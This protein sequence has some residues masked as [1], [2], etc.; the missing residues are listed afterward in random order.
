MKS[1]KK[2]PPILCI[3]GYAG[4]GNLG[5]DALLAGLLEGLW[6]RGIAPG[7]VILLSGRPRCDA[8]RFGVKCV[9]RKNPVAILLAL[10]RADVFLSGGG[11]LLQNRTGRRSLFYY[12]SLLR[13]ARFCGCRTVVLG[14][15]GPLSG[16]GARRA[17]K[18]ELAWCAAL[19]LRDRTS[20][21]LAR[22]LGVPP[23]RVTVGADPAF[24]LPDPPPLRA[25]FLISRLVGDL[26]KPFLCVF[27]CGGVPV[28]G[29]A[30]ALRRSFPGFFPLFL[31]CDPARDAAP[32]RRL[33]RLFGGV[34]YAPR[35][36]GEVLALVSAA[37]PVLSCR[38]H[39]LILSVRAGA[40]CLCFSGGDPKLSAFCQ[41][42]GIPCF[43]AGVGSV[44]LPSAASFFALPAPDPSDFCR[45]AAKDLAIL[46]KMV[47]NKSKEARPATVRGRRRFFYEKRAA[48]GSAPP[49]HH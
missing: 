19:L 41:S 26:Q 47:Y 17:V 40:R 5:D 15:I 4:C 9:G 28:A 6:R 23:A 42:A 38:L 46:C 18:K 35:D 20:A 34:V 16:A 39:P 3:G 7:S 48:G 11:T 44:I 49:N 37:P 10:L 24:L 27:P 12:L 29:L 25:A 14:G 22:E 1:H 33:Q 32:A 31:L 43:P 30:A 21:A 36:A 13:L 2:R 8:R 45:K